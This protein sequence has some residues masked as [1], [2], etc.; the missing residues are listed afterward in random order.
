VILTPNSV[1]LWKN[2]V[3]RHTLSHRITQQKLH[4]LAHDSEK[5]K[6]E[7]EEEE[8]GATK[9]L[10]A[11][12]PYSPLVT[13]KY[14]KISIYMHYPSLLKFKPNNQIVLLKYV[15]TRST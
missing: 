5:A 8:E 2:K 1:I 4:Q 7:E 15:Q 14:V 6:E 10:R 13:T 3:L 12:C 9:S 11:A